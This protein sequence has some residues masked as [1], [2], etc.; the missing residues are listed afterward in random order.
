MIY[1]WQKE[2]WQWF[3][4]MQKTQRLPHALLLIGISGIGK[5]KFAEQM[6]QALLCTQNQSTD[7]QDC[8]CHSCCLLQGRAHPNVLWVEPEKKGQVIKVDQIREVIDFVNHSALHAGYRIVIIH[9][10]DDMNISAANALL[11]TLEEPSAETLFI[12]I[13]TQATQLPATIRSRCQRLIF[14]QPNPNEVLPWL[15]QAMGEVDIAPELLLKITNGAPLAALNSLNE[16]HLQERKILFDVLVQ[17]QKK[18]NNPLSAAV[19]IQ[20]M[21][22]LQTIDF[23]LSWL[24]DLLKLHVGNKKITNQDYAVQLAELKQNTK[25]KAPLKLLDI[26]QTTRVQLCRGFNLNKQLVLENIF[27]QWSHDAIS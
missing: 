15:Q 1:P 8:H 6:A 25:L 9:T 2:Q 5:L 20:E 14:N 24:I 4:N 12:L 18:E 19:T 3:R 27:I 21:E 10:A 17:L 16:N 7:T 26:L 22:L 23:M 11:K 13:S